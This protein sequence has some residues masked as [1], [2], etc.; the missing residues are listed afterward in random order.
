M[1][2]E[3]ER[4]E[5]NYYEWKYDTNSETPWIDVQQYA[6]RV[7]IQPEKCSLKAF[8]YSYFL[9]IK[10]TL[11]TQPRFSYKN[12]TLV[13][14]ADEEQIASEDIVVE[15]PTVGIAKT[16][17]D[18]IIFNIDPFTEMTA[19][20]HDYFRIENTGNIP[21][22]I[23]VD[24]GSTDEIL[25]YAKFNSRIAPY[26]SGV[27][28]GLRIQSEVWPPGIQEFEGI[29]SGEV[30]NASTI[31]VTS[32]SFDT[33]VGVAAPTLEMYVAH[34]N[35]KIET[36]SSGITFQ[37]PETLEM[38][39]DETKDINVYISGDGLVDI[40]IRSKNLS[41][42]NIWSG[43]NEVDPPFTVS[44]TAISEQI[45]KIRVQ[46][47]RETNAAYLYY[48]VND[49]QNMKDYKTKISIGPPQ[50]SDSIVTVD[51]TLIIAI[52]V[53]I[54]MVAGYMIYSQMKYRRR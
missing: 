27:F 3:S 21:L 17:G 5:T 26:E 24:Y 14:Y 49:G 39:E 34:A 54:L 20:G 4:D 9:G 25:E 22:I 18:I 15:K 38:D 47:I 31:P 19:T 42:L 53:V 32:Y 51:N 6:G 44:S 46:A 52:V 13:V 43:N 10:D 48:D 37:Y 7:Y 50:S 8:T 35:Y 28:D 12:W 16:H 41:I 29:V 1:P 45:I 23:N 11:P 40:N 33:S 2:T 36:F 30:P